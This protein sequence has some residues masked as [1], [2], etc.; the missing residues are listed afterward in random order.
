MR[1]S[2]LGTSSRSPGHGMPHLGIEAS[3]PLSYPDVAQQSGRTAEKAKGED[4]NRLPFPLC[5]T[6]RALN[7]TREPICWVTERESFWWRF[8]SS[9]GPGE[10]P[11]VCSLHLFPRMTPEDVHLCR[12]PVSTIIL[13]CGTSLMAATVK[14]LSPA[15]VPCTVSF[16]LRHHRPSSKSALLMRE[17]YR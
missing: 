4:C 15:L 16:Q 14:T 3:L 13:R 1:A 11:E 10:T 6:D 5:L 2:S 8:C 7:T 17:N 12:K 9:M